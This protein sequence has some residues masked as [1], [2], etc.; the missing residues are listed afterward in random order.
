M[1]LKLVPMSDGQL[2]AEL[3]HAAAVWF[4]NTDLLLLEELIRR[5]RFCQ[6]ETDRL[7]TLVKL[8]EEADA[9]QL[10]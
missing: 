7:H 4:K 6:Q 3:R 5:Y 1:T 9:D 8:L 2:V 10:G